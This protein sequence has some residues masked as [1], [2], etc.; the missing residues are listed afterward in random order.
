M[1]DPRVGFS[2]AASTLPP[3][4]AERL[5]ANAARLH[6][7]AGRTLISQGESSTN[8]YVV[9]EGLLQVM[10]FSIDGREIILRNI[11]E[12]ELFGE[13]AAIDR[14]PR[15]ATIVALSDCVL[16][17]VSAESFCA[18]IEESPAASMWLARRFAGQL[19]D[20][21]S[22]LLER[23]ALRVRSRLH[24]ELLRRCREVSADEDVV[25]LDGAPTHAELA[26][27]IGTHR[28]AVTREMR[29]LV[30][31]GIVKQQRRCIVVND[32]RALARL[33][34]EV[35]GDPVQAGDD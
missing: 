16:A 30:D 14:R 23:T 35:L 21:T 24:C 8:A 11:A 5:L 33:V 3:K 19:R 7:K 34:Q 15:S 26:A 29:H 32:T 27:R 4:L 1:K 2:P 31:L 17:S 6:A 22:R 18:A 9:R 10:L 12:G 25:T 28:E 13:I 20:L